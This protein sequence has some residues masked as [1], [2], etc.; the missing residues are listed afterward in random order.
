MI[1]SIFYLVIIVVLAVWLVRQ[2]NRERALVAL[3]DHNR[4]ERKTVYQFLNALGERL[5][6]SNIAL[7]PALEIIM[8]FIVDRS[9]AEAGAVFLLDPHDN[10]LS[11][12]VVKGMFPPLMPT[13]GYVL[14]KQK[15]LSER[16]KRERIPLGQGIIGEAAASGMPIL[17]SD[18]ANDPRVPKVAL[19]YL[20]IRSIMIAPLTSRGRISGVIAI[21]N[22]RGGEIFTEENLDLLRA[23]ADQAA[24]TVEM[25]K[26]YD[27][28]AEKQRIEQELRVA[29]EF[30]KMLLPSECPK[31]DG[32][33][34]AAFSEP[35]LEVGGDY[36][37]FFFVDDARRYLGVV[38]ADVSG[39]GIPGAF[40]MAMV[41]C[42][43]RVVA[44]GNL[45]P[46]E[47][48]FKANERLYAD[49]KENVFVTMT[50]GI[51]DTYEHTFR[52]ARAGHEPLV[53]IRRDSPNVEL[54]SPD[55]IALAMVTNDM[56]SFVQEAVLPLTPGET[57]IMY[58]DGV[59][60]AMDDQANEYGQRRFFDLIAS[61][62]ELKPQEIIAKTLQDI[63]RFTRGYPQHD[64]ITMVAIRVHDDAAASKSSVPVA[65][66]ARA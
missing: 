27:D 17:V 10:Q 48:L 5:T 35:A 20:T 51:L 30:Q 60:E 9:D 50:Y 38:I 16:I 59:V 44:H 62:R 6:T 29:H 4:I 31:I 64:D 23:L 33:D 22:K 61:S 11:A 26:L 25:V 14:T 1:G 46:R 54:S 24:S 56:F 12:R 19:D 43:I 8:D 57:A 2:R 58:T 42:T 28:L 41:R 65:A 66:P 36:Y 3:V 34:I 63:Q 37:D 13:T 18:A 55:G 39:K 47:V 40:V 45:S 52:F 32:Y 7:E 21:V 15:Y 49:T 53:T